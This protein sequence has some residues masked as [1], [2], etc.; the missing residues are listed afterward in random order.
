MTRRLLFCGLSSLTVTAACFAA[1]SASAVTLSP[2]PQIPSRVVLDRAPA[3]G[4]MV[5]QYEA[6]VELK[7]PGAEFEIESSADLLDRM[8]GFVAD[9]TSEVRDGATYLRL[10]FGCKCVPAV[11]TN[12][13]DQVTIDIVGIPASTQGVDGESAAQAGGPAPLTSRRPP[14]KL[15]SI[16]ATSGT[17]PSEIDVDEARERLITQLLRA[18]D[19]GLVE[20]QPDAEL[21]VKETAGSPREDKPMSDPVVDEPIAQE[22]SQ[23]ELIDRVSAAAAAGEDILASISKPAQSGEAGE[24]A[25]AETDTSRGLDADELVSSPNATRPAAPAGGQAEPNEISINDTAA[26]TNVIAAE[27]PTCFES[28]VF[29]F[30]DL[31]S[32]DSLGDKIS[33]L[34]RGLIGEFDRADPDQAIA[35]AKLYVFAG[36][37]DEAREVLRSF[38]ADHSLAP[39]YMEMSRLR[40][41]ETLPAD[42]SILKTDCV[43]EQAL[44][45]AFA[46][47]LASNGSL[48]VQSEIA[49]GRALERMPVELRENVAAWIGFAAANDGDWDNARR[50]E[51]IVS[52]AATVMP[53]MSGRAHLLSAKLSFWND[54]RDDGIGHLRSATTSDPV[55]ATE[56]LYALGDLA[57]RDPNWER[58]RTENLRD[59]LGALARML[60]NTSE[61]QRAFEMEIKLANRVQSHGES[62]TMLSHGVDTGLVDED[63]QFELLSEVITDPTS[64]PDAQPLAFLYLN[65]PEK[66]APALTQPGFRTEL[67]RSMIDLDVPRLAVDV[68]AEEDFADVDLTLRLAEALEESGDVRETMDVLAKLPE[69]AEKSRLLASTLRSS[70]EPTQAVSYLDRALPEATGTNAEIELLMSKAEA[71]QEAGDLAT[72]LDTLVDLFE[73]A[74]DPE[75]AQ[76][77]AMIAL[78]SGRSGIPE[79]VRSHLAENDPTLLAGLEPLFGA[80]TVPGDFDT[81]EAIDGYLER[82]NAEETAIQE[83]LNDG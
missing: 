74:P 35:L 32:Y 2:D 30:S 13:Q 66:F 24:G 29:D 39:I 60:G 59:D 78:A 42:A 9:A 50:M 38:A 26:T 6:N 67:A 28:S 31:A 47:A 5:R 18:A 27:E 43:G 40:D 58:S 73:I 4:W 23:A 76:E 19:A 79:S 61:G 25:A 57:L 12:N 8:E 1:H 77:I 51:S 70:G 81:P 68:L 83:L 16:S 80:S 17:N 14:V 72:A 22:P 7:F 21:T 15:A 65:D 11:A 41:G 46:A 54:A 69:S 63:R 55:S 44:W 36:F 62:M 34:R 48:A 64:E 49:A 45:R 33:D 37:T 75:R 20:M 10:T 52:R 71:A 3:T 56:A 82:L 53:E